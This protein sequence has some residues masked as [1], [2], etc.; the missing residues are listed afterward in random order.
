MYMVKFIHKTSNFIDKICCTMIIVILA[1]MVLVT[2]VQIICRVF[3][4]ALSWSE[5]LARYLL[6]YST[7]FG[8]GVV[9]K[10]NGHIAVTMVQDLLP[11]N[12]RKYSDLLVN[13]LCGILFAIATAFGFKYTSLQGNQLSAA[14]RIPMKYIYMSIPIGFSVMILHAIDNSLR[15]FAGKGDIE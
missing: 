9:Y 7:F 6:V 11:E 13:V 12:F 10:R 15:L 2:T 4:S 5:E 3:F 8:A 1:L 14:L